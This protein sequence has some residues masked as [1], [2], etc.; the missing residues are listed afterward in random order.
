MEKVLIIIAT[1]NGE[2][3]IQKCLSSI[4][5][6][7]YNVIVIDNLSTDNTIDIIRQ[8]YPKVELI[9]SKENLG[10]GR[11]N[12]IG[13]QKVLDGGYDYAFLLNQDA[14]LEQDT[15]DRLIEQIKLHPDYGILSP[16]QRDSIESYIE[17]QFDKYLKNNDINMQRKGVQEVDF[18]NAA[19][20]L[21]TR[22]TIELVGGFDPIYPHYGEDS[23]YVNRLHYW[24]K[25][26]GVDLSIVAY[27]DRG[28]SDEKIELL[29]EKRILI[30]YMMIL[31][32]IN[33]SLSRQIMGLLVLCARKWLKS[34]MRLQ[35]YNTW[36]YVKRWFLA[37]SKLNRVRESRT[38]TLNKKAYLN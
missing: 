30:G 32:N 3:W 33:H 36:I 10:F 21:I 16:L 22:E 35:I 34:I 17:K 27:H 38:N 29:D 9:C 5:M 37:I 19:L 20:W 13:L 8:E 12:N 6:Q 23:D 31:N 24:G 25:K 18:V 7:R 15:I 28:C 4:D 11:A 14:W 1:Y 26:I 2:S